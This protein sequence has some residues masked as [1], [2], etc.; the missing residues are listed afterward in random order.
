MNIPDE[1]TCEALWDEAHLPKHIRRHCE[2]VMRRACALVEELEPRWC[3]DE[4][5]V[6]A[7]ALLHDIL[8]L[9]NRHAKA[10]EAFL[11]ARGY[12]E[13]ARIV[14]AHMNLS[15]DMLEHIDE[16]AIVFLA[17]KMVIGEEECS[18]A[19]R[20]LAAAMKG[21]NPVEMEN[22]A[23]RVEALYELLRTGCAARV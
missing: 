19:A 17:D 6:A 9:E 4:D 22:I 7:G 3:F 23:R 13:V 16:R 21:A 12:P 11:R 14:G 1:K 10:G 15:E 18:I 8:R 20:Y 5:L 2:A